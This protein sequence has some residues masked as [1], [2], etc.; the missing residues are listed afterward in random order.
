MDGTSLSRIYPMADNLNLRE[1]DVRLPEP[2]ALTGLGY[3]EPG[4]DDIFEMRIDYD[5]GYRLYCALK[6]N[7]LVLLPLRG[8][9]SSQQRH[10]EGEEG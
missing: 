9:K 2:P 7:E 4:G 1:P 10:R 5:P 3:A 8:D 6:G